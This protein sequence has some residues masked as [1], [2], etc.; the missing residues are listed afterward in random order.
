MV[1]SFLIG[2]LATYLAPGVASAQ[3][4]LTC[5]AEAY[6]K[7]RQKYVA[8][9]EFK[10]NIHGPVSDQFGSG[11]CHPLK[12]N[13]IREQK[14][15]GRKLSLYVYANMD[16]GDAGH[17]ILGYRNSFPEFFNFQVASPV[18]LDAQVTCEFK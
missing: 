14:P 17:L 6:D 15:Y 2:M 12:M 9:G 1:K 10:W 8:C 4:V 3:S 13:V 5:R 16:R 11:A 18:G 7:S